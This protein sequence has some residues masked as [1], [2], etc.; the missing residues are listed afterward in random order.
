[1][2]FEQFVDMVLHRALTFVSPSVWK[3][4]FEFYPWDNYNQYLLE[5]E[6]LTE[7]MD[8]CYGIDNGYAQRVGSQ[9]REAN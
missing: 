3:D 9:F 4:T 6:A 8:C 5:E 2:R 1:M 7:G